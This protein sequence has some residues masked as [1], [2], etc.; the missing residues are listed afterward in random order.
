MDEAH[1]IYNQSAVVPFRRED[2]DVQ[3][4]LITSRRR[5]RWVIPKGI[6]EPD[7]TPQE[8]AKQEAFEEAGISGRIIQEAIG[9]YTYDK[10][11]GTCRVKVFLLEVENIFDD[12]PESFFRTREWLSLEEAIQRVDEEGLKDILRS[13]PKL[14]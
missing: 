13:I 11:G 2:N 10:W 4:L 3:I 12:W 5:K 6:V 14:I 7:L 8:S 1:W 9:E